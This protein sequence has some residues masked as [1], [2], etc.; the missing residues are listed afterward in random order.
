MTESMVSVGTCTASTPVTSAPVPTGEAIHAVGTPSDG[1]Y[2]WK[3][4]VNDESTVFDSSAVGPDVGERRARVRPVLDV[5]AEVDA[6]VRRVDD[7]AVEVEEQDVLVAQLVDHLAEVVVVV[8]PG[9]RPLAAVVGCVERE[10]GVEVVV[11]GRRV[12]RLQVRLGRRCRL[13][14]RRVG[15]RAGG[16]V[17]PG[18]ERA[19][20]VG[21]D[22]L[23]PGGVD[24]L[25]VERG[26][27]GVEV[28]RRLHG[29]VVAAV[30]H[31]GLLHPREGSLDVAGARLADA[32]DL[33]ERR[34]AE[35][36]TAVH[37]ADAADHDRREEADREQHD[38]QGRLDVE[39]TAPEEGPQ[40]RATP[41][42]SAR[43]LV[44]ADGAVAVGGARHAWPRSPRTSGPASLD[45]TQ[46]HLIRPPDVPPIEGT[47]PE[48]SHTGDTPRTPATFSR[49][50]A[51]PVEETPVTSSTPPAARR[52]RRTRRRG[53]AARRACRA[54]RCGR[55]RRRR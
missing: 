28:E 49:R 15:R 14:Q 4:V 32:R 21:G 2:G 40:R 9:L 48:L 29:A 8:G 42:R 13:D 41:R 19:L 37:V 22:R 43:R 20:V 26:E 33:V 12:D 6:R 44:R 52:G 53:R 10:R 24:R 51:T 36:V 34:R 23:L 45:M 1:A 35:R 39:R 3:S 11:E 54:R 17:E 31:D 16:L 50:S 38:E 47:A 30:E 18:H 27:A 7:V 25:L 5:R 55:R 46:P